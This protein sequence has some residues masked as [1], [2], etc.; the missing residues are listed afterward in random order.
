MSRQELERAEVEFSDQ[1]A[2][3]EAQASAPRT[4][5]SLDP[6]HLLSSRS[7]RDYA[8][9]DIRV[10]VFCERDDVLDAVER[11]LV[12]YRAPDG[13]RTP[14]LELHYVDDLAGPV[15]APSDPAL[16]TV[17]EPPGGVVRHAP[18]TDA[19]YAELRDVRLEADMRRGIVHIA[20]GAW[21]GAQRYVAT[22]TL[23]TIALMEAFKRHHR[24]ALHAGCL[25]L[26]GRALLLAGTSGAGKSTLAL[27]LARLG[28]DYL[29][30]D[31]VFLSPQQDDSLQVIGFADAVG[32]T[33][34]TVRLIGELAEAAGSDP[35]PGFPKHLIRVEDV[36]RAPIIAAA[37]PRV[38]VFPEISGSEESSLT[39][40]QSGDAWLRLV[41]DVLLTDEAS[42]QA[43]LT[44][45]AGLTQGLSCHRL[46]T[47]RDLD[48]AARLVAELL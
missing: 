18:E 41:P 5:P 40:L 27:A 48:A 34:G 16:R 21:S 12:R 33:P 9:A 20:G 17:Y 44:A 6:L 47:G 22:H 28:L 45:I 23:T 19:L 13:A 42:S 14:D 3:S 8:L 30:D 15:V 31:L 1:A 2:L 11:R 32:V 36:F 46:Q 24:F 38:L 37:Q 29:S 7:R 10:G 25:A 35:E 39:P 43:H 26:D 4:P